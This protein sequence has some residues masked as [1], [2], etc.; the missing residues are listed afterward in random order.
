MTC[1]DVCTHACLIVRRRPTARP[2]RRHR[3][4]CRRGA[5]YLSGTSTTSRRRP[6]GVI[7]GGGV[8]G[9]VVAGSRGHGWGEPGASRVVIT[10]L[11]DGE[12]AVR[13]NVLVRLELIAGGPASR[14]LRAIMI[15]SHDS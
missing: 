3:P 1:A 10:I 14:V 11:G 15:H 5:G 8:A 12:T 9:T 2:P 7:A 13:L 6:Y 4:A